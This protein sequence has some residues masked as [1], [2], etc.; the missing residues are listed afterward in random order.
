M[1]FK[2]PLV[3]IQ[4]LGPKDGGCRKT[5]SVFWYMS[6]WYTSGLLQYNHGRSAAETASIAATAAGSNPVTRTI[7]RVIPFGMARLIFSGIVLNWRPLVAKSKPSE[8][9]LIWKGRRSLRMCSFRGSSANRGNGTEQASSDA[10]A[11]SNPVTR[12][13]NP[14]FRKKLGIFLV[15]KCGSVL[16]Y[17]NCTGTRL[18]SAKCLVEH[19][20]SLLLDRVL[21]VQIVLCH[22]QVRM[23]HHALD[24]G[25]VYAQC[26]HLRNIGMSAGMR[27]QFADAFDRA[28]PNC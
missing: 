3:Q 11:G 24:R 17:R 9:V 25:E 8:A 16:A 5:P 12:T 22:I 1:G 23:T 20:H 7:K 19:V 6:A 2:R 13:K 4:S 18:T 28:S 27:R 21:N 26:L 10:A 14:Q 15:K